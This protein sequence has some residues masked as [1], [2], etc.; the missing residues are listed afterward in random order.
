MSGIRD[1]LTYANVT[2]TLALIVALGTGGAYAAS[3]IGPNDIKENAVRS[4]HIKE[5]EVRAADLAPPDEW[6]SLTLIEDW[7]PYT[8][9]GFAPPGCFRDPLG[10][11]HLRGAASAPGLSTQPFDLPAGCRPGSTV[12]VVAALLSS[13]GA[14]KDTLTVHISSTTGR[15]LIEGYI[16]AANEKIALDGITFRA[17]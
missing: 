4:K 8:S 15:A 11:V 7:T 13:V 6:T 10:I 9:V 2:A 5:G 16:P 1:R 17:P 3:K 12:E 14:G